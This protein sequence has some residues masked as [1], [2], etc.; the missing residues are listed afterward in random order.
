M[1]F[2]ALRQSAKAHEGGGERI[3]PA[4][5]AGDVR[6][7]RPQREGSDLLGDLRGAGQPEGLIARYL[8]TGYRFS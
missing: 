5:G 8:V 6:A 4:L 7:F 1:T 2:V 3:P